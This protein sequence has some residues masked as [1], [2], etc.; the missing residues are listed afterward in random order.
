M[1]DL[2][3]K[4]GIAFDARNSHAPLETAG[5]GGVPRGEDRPVAAGAAGVGARGG[6]ALALANE[7]NSGSC[8]TAS[9]RQRH[10]SNSLICD[11]NRS[12]SGAGEHASYPNCAAIYGM[13][14]EQLSAFLVVNR[15]SASIWPFRVG[16]FAGHRVKFVI[17]YAQDQI[18]RLIENLGIDG[19]SLWRSH[20]RK[21]LTLTNGNETQFVIGRLNHKSHITRKNNKRI[22]RNHVALA[23]WPR[24]RLIGRHQPAVSFGFIGRIRPNDLIGNSGSHKNYSDRASHPF[25]VEL[26]NDGHFVNGQQ[27]QYRC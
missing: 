16:D 1:G 17:F 22:G 4:E 13:H 18:A 3:I 15:K 7:N 23:N 19:N 5:A 27:T 20:Y 14:P 26:I 6:A 12:V 10:S 2:G 21:R 25:W 9:A 8:D 24:R 11:R